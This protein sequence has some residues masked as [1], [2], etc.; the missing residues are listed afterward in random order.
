[1]DSVH[2]QWTTVGSHG[3]PST[4]GGVYT[5][6]YGSGGM[7]AKAGPPTATKYRNS[8][9]G[10]KKGEGSTGILSQASPRLRRWCGGQVVV[11]KLQ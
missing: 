3:P 10:A 4:G 11:M 2:G 6:T 7:L 1:V 5:R 9:A 8:P